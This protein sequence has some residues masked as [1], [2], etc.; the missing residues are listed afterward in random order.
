MAR[1][2]A[3]CNIMCPRTQ[4]ACPVAGLIYRTQRCWRQPSDG[5]AML[6]LSTT[7]SPGSISQ[8]LTI[9]ADCI[10]HIAYVPVGVKQLQE[11]L[12]PLILAHLHAADAGLIGLGLAKRAPGP[13]PPACNRQGL[14]WTDPG[15]A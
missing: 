8:Q 11:L 2:P 14:E 7:S 1:L 6:M 4:A 9:V 10:N 15:K 13:C 12:G 3:W 5:V